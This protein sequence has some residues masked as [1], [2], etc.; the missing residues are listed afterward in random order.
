MSPYLNILCTISVQRQHTNNNTNFGNDDPVEAT[1][2]MSTMCPNHYGQYFNNWYIA[3][4]VFI[5]S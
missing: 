1:F 4:F 5:T 2:S 3:P